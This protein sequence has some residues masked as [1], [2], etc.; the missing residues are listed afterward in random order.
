MARLP[1][2]VQ[3]KLSWKSSPQE[4]IE[5]ETKHR[6]ELRETPKSLIHVEEHLAQ[7]C[8]DGSHGTGPYF[9]QWILFDDLWAVAH[10][11]LADALLTWCSRWDVLTGS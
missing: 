5:I 7:M 1:G 8:L 4:L 9:G 10:P 2:A 3:D 11:E 6:S